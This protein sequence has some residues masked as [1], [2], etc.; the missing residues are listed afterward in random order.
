MHRSYDKRKQ[1]ALEIEALIKS[2]QEIKDTDRINAIIVMLGE[3]FATSATS[4]HRKGGLIGL[5]AT[6]IG[7][8]KYSRFHQ[9]K[10]G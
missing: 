4:N 8:M 6:A 10:H 3:D 9:I 5:A 7:L 1:A 2:L